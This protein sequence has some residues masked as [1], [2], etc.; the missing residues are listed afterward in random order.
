MTANK[1]PKATAPARIL[2]VDNDANICNYVKR[3]LNQRYEVEVAADAVEALGACHRIPALVLADIMMLGQNFELLRE[4]RSNPKTRDIPI[5][6]LLTRTQEDSCTEN[7]EAE[8]VDYLVKPFSARELLARV[9]INIELA[10]LRQEGTRREQELQTEVQEAK[11]NLERVL[12]SIND[13]FLVLDRNWRYIYVNNRVAEVVGMRKEDLLGKNVW[14]LFPDTV[15]TLF[16]TEVHRAVREQIAV[17]FE[18][19]YP[20]WNRWFENHIYPT[21]NSLTI[22]VTDITARKQ[23]EEALQHSEERYRFI[24]ES[25]GVSI[26]EEDFT[27]VYALIQELKA[28]NVANLREYL[29]SHPDV[30]QRAIQLVQIRDVNQQTLKMFGARTK[31]ELLNSLATIFVPETTQVF[32]E[33]LIALAEEH[34]YYSSETILRTLKGEQRNILFTVTFPPPEAGYDRVLVSILDI[35]ARQQV[36][37]ALRQSEERFQAFMSHNPAA[38]WIA[39]IQGRLLYLNP[40]YFRLFQFPQ[41]DAVG[42]TIPEIFSEKFAQ[43]F[44]ENNRKVFETQQVVETVETAPRPDGSIGDF[45]VYKFPILYETGETLLGGVAVDIT[46]RH[47]A[48]EALRQSENRYRTLANAVP[49]LI[50]INEPNGNVQ[51]YNQ[52]WQDYTGVPLELGVGLWVEIIHPDDFQF[53]VETRTKAIQASKAYEVECRLKRFDQT[54]RWHLARVVP[55]KDE[56]GRVLYWFGTATD[57]DDR[58]QAEAVLQQYNTRLTLALDAARMGSWDW[59][60]QTGDVVWSPFHEIIFGYKPGTPNR[61]YQDWAE[62]VHPDDLPQVLATVEAA[63]IEKRDYKDEYRVLWKDGSL[64][65]VSSFGRFQYD[66]K[67]QP[68]HM[69]GMLFDI[70]ERKHTESER[71]QLLIREQAA[72]AEAEAAN[73]IKDEFLAVLSHELRS[74]LNPILG[75]AKLLQSREFDRVT[76]K[77]GLETIERNAKLQIQLI[78]DLLDVSRILRGKLILNMAPINLVSIIE[79]AMETVRLAAEA[80]TIQM[81]TMLDVTVGQVLG[82]S[83]RLQQIVW[84]LLSNAVKFT[85]EGGQV[86]V[87]LEHINSQAQITVSDTGKG[88]SA[89][90]LPYVFDYFRQADS[91]TT[92]QFGGLGLGLAIVRHLVELHGGTVWAE[93]PGEGQ[94]ATFTLS[95][96]LIKEGRTIDDITTASSLTASTILPLAGI[97]ILIVDDEEDN[98]DFFSFVLEQSGAVVTAVASAGEALQSLV[99]SKP[100]LLLSDIGMPE[101]DGYML[102]RLVR[103]LEAEQGG[104]QIPAIALTAYAGEIDQQ[105]A[106][107]AGFQRHIAKPVAPEELIE[108]IS[109]LV[110]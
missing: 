91:T 98:R 1:E 17:S 63:M 5:I 87:R 84:N 56:Q 90:F 8:A 19:F 45:L 26:W 58:K 107:A 44:L 48:E 41:Q 72:R 81:R 109:N 6:L 93:S 40:T 2:L 85:P 88:I 68:I 37:E 29:N 49:Q 59:D 23:A 97:Q 35:T 10:R 42:K 32:V 66:Q 46:E 12:F 36:K 28:E 96:P 94:G 15:G 9:K 106:L 57:I 73:R 31:V 67:G 54:Y 50:W 21:P 80:K 104:H 38:A 101:M 92:R 103:A 4:L 18:Y 39:D 89:D 99:Q 75:W 43:Q 25:T 27:Q 34:R 47:R 33:E 13:Q 20:T 77:K 62:R 82:D 102:M 86:E 95:L 3:L 51:F 105:R 78:E 52:R 22:F 83:A 64:R 24:F 55:L 30:V 14:E 69:L 79:A 71:E 76:L 16:Y 100:D 65:W 53:V 108:E 11:D 74:P 7:L 60:I 70:T 110:S 61:T